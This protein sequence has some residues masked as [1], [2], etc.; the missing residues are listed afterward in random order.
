VDS[1]HDA[2][3]PYEFHT[4]SRSK[5]AVTSVQKRLEELRQQKR[6]LSRKAEADACSQNAQTLLKHVQAEMEEVSADILSRG[7]E[8]KS[9]GREAERT[10]AQKLRQELTELIAEQRIVE[11][12][13]GTVKRLKDECQTCG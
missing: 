10:H 8:Q 4:L 9:L 7:E 3:K 2:P 13:V 11:K 12:A 1:E 6:L 5:N